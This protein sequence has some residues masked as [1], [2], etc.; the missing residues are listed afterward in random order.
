MTRVLITGAS[1]GVGRATAIELIRRGHE[2]V[3]TARNADALADLGAALTIE[4]DVTDQKSVDA[5][6]LRSGSIDALVS[7]AGQT[8][9][10]PVET[11]PLSEFERMF[12]LNTMGA[13]R[14]TKA[15]LP[16]MR[17][18]RAGRLLYVSSILGRIA[19]Q[20]GGA[21]AASKW[22]LEAIA[23]TIALETR[24][25]NIAVSL[26]E[27]G[28]ISTVGPNSAPSYLEIDGPYAPPAVEPSATRIDDVIS[29]AEVAYAIAD[30]LESDQPPLRVPVGVAA[31]F[32][33]ADR[34]AAGESEMFEWE[35]R[36]L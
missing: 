4:M 6:I 26:L 19:V 30:T 9:R 33:L 10:G 35:V 12:Q 27:P 2:V 5:A 25:F 29:A 18:R 1:Q 20:G 34:S 3:A 28:R 16:Q 24:P 23:E 11:T 21:Y 31:T 14:V 15:L 13:L 8:V 22:G 7:N 17:E 32:G 36:L